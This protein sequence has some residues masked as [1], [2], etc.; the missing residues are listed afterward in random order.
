MIIVFNAKSGPIPSDRGERSPQ[1][2]A[3]R[4]ISANGRASVV[5]L[6]TPS[7]T[8][9]SCVKASPALGL[10]D[11]VLEQACSAHASD[12]HLINARSPKFLA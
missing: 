8:E 7:T 12:M 4:P 2:T 10:D 6:P 5:P 1:P 11:F 3:A 9:R